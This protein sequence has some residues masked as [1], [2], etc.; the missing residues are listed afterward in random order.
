MEGLPQ[1][2]LEGWPKLRKLAAEIS[3]LERQ[4]AQASATASQLQAQLPAARDRDLEAQ[5]QAVRKGKD[6]GQPTHEAEVN[7]ELEAA[8]RDEA[9]LRRAAD[10]ARTDHNAFVA[11]HQAELYGDVVEF[12]N[13]L[14]GEIAEHARRILPAYGR[15]EDLH[16]LLKNLSPPPAPAHTDA[17]PQ[18]LTQVLLGPTVTPRIGPDRGRVEEMVGYLAGLAHQQGDNDAAA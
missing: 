18:R 10:S 4:H 11:K 3:A 12:R 8:R 6:R 9:V 17:G 14:A 1:E 7:R 15:F 2:V 5:A 13:T 16:Y